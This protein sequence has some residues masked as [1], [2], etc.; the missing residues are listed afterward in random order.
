[1]TDALFEEVVA[2]KLEEAPVMDLL[3]DSAKKRGTLIAAAI[4]N[5][6]IPVMVIVRQYNNLRED[7][8][9]NASTLLLFCEVVGS[10]DPSELVS[11]SN[12]CFDTP[13]EVVGRIDATA[14][15]LRNELSPQSS[16]FGKLASP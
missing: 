6:M 1:V 7:F 2:F 9:R 11:T 4:M 3:G 10:I 12:A 15:S 8:S 5:A 14:F 13:K 16:A